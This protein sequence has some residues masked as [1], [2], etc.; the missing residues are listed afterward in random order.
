MKILLTNDDSHQSPLLAFVIQ[1]LKKFA[2]LT[3]VVPKHEQSWNEN[4]FSF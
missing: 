1:N 4:L 3:I 2:E